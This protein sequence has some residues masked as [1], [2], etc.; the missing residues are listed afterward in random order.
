MNFARRLQLSPPCR[1][2]R[3]D[4]LDNGGGAGC[5]GYDDDG[6]GGGGAGERV[7]TCGYLK[8]YSATI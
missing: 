7:H 5:G 4:S 3:R 8:V 2:E 1:K 6:G